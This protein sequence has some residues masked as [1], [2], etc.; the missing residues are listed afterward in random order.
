MRRKALSLLARREH[1][2]AELARKLERKGFDGRHIDGVLTELEGQR[3]L[4]DARFAESFVQSRIA[5]GYGPA[6]IRH[7]LRERGVEARLIETHLDECPLDWV[8]EIARVRR[9]RFGE[10]MPDGHHERA[11][12]A[13][14]LQYR[15]FSPDQIRRLLEAGE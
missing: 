7:Q 12:Q 8:A 2:R 6:R 4:C 3:L 1:S 10:A 9:K 15:G 11:R 13:R 14:F 5:K